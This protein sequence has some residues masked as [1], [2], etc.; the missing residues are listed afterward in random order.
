MSI[1]SSSSPPTG[2]RKNR[3]HCHRPPSQG[4]P[5]GGPRPW[6][7]RPLF[8]VICIALVALAVAFGPRLARLPGLVRALASDLSYYRSV[9]AS[10][11]TAMTP[12]GLDELSRRLADTHASIRAL[13]SDWGILLRAGK[14]LRWLPRYGGDLAAA[15]DLMLIADYGLDAALA[16]LPVIQPALESTDA[17]DPSEALVVLCQTVGTQRDAL[18]RA[19]YTLARLEEGRRRIDI[20]QLS[21]RLQSLLAKADALLPLAVA[22]PDLLGVA[23]AL[24]GANGPRQYLILA[25]NSD[26]LRATGGFI[27]GVGLLTVEGGSVTSLMFSDSFSIVDLQQPHPVSPPALDVHMWAG[28]LLFRDA[29]WWADFPT[30]AKMAQD[31]YAQD[32]GQQTDGV[33]AIDTQA[34]LLMVGALGPIDMRDYKETISVDNLMDRMQHYWAS[35]DLGPDRASGDP[36]WWQHRKDFVGEL[37]GALV[38]RLLRPAGVDPL[39]LAEAIT[40]LLQEKHLLLYLPEA[41]G[42]L[43]TRGWD[44]GLANPQGDYLM[45]VDSNVGFNKVNAV[46]RESISYTVTIGARGGA[47]A[48]LTIC[49][50]HGSAVRLDECVH[51]ARYGKAY[52]DMTD[53]CYWDYVRVLVPKGSVLTLREGLDNGGLAEPEGERDAFDGLLVLPPGESR[54]VTFRY[55]LPS[56]RLPYSLYVQKQPGT[57]A[58]PLHVAIR[59]PGRP[60]VVFATDLSRDRQFALR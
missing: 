32:A 6:Y 23:P 50:Q 56:L 31:L 22:A 33:I 12:S 3:A 40:R 17:S 2:A 51:E 44:G 37:A 47:D 13:H 14:S 5:Q 9:Q 34:L 25:Q 42:M 29:N 46:V 55:T 16:L 41:A 4:G 43:A 60:V 49:Y 11:D 27:S 20:R 54:E 35:P 1:P 15:A 24:L 45:V 19:S 38:D 57:T 18:E 26:E 7:Q 8:L 30:S 39:K 59:A 21:P 53:R 58:V 10:L 52:T 36:D 28:M 48:E